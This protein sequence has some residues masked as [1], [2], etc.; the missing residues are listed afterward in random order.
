M[1]IEHIFKQRIPQNK[2]LFMT[3]KYKIEK[4]FLYPIQRVFCSS[5]HMGWNIKKNNPKVQTLHVYI[6]YEDF[7]I[8][9]KF[10]KWLIKSFLVNIVCPNYCWFKNI[11]AQQII[12]LKNLVQEKFQV[13]KMFGPG[14]KWS[15][16]A[17]TVVFHF[18]SLKYQN[19]KPESCQY[20]A[21]ILDNV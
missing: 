15:Q 6:Y 8:K 3:H 7:I 12:G 20:Q 14:R 19:D 5:K 2:K 16:R 18:E 11:L 4:T 17:N 21:L 13:Q 9:I 10:P 1:A